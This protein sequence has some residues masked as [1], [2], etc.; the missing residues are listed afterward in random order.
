MAE[1][2]NVLVFWQLTDFISSSVSEHCWHHH[3]L[4][5]NAHRRGLY[6]EILIYMLNGIHQI[7]FPTCWKWFRTQ[8]STAF[9][10]L[11]G[12]ACLHIAGEGRGHPQRAT[13][14]EN[15]PLTVPNPAEGPGC[16]IAASGCL[17]LQ[18]SLC[19]WMN[20]LI[21]AQGQFFHVHACNSYSLAKRFRAICKSAQ[22]FQPKYEAV[23]RISICVLQ[24]NWS[25]LCVS[26][27][28]ELLLNPQY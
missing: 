27:W 23:I 6:Y 16:C 22:Y 7:C 12:A 1:E 19:K 4:K 8:C 21:R 25:G 18:C 24:F 20:R 2:N 13:Q 17:A 28:W 3:A 11:C 14:R 5:K 26:R 10:L 15:V 9:Y